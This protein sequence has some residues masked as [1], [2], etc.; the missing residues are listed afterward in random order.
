MAI[1]SGTTPIDH[2]SHFSPGTVF[3]LS[4]VGKKYAYTELY[5]FPTEVG[6]FDPNAVTLGPDGNLY[7]T[8]FQGGSTY[9]NSLNGYGVVFEIAL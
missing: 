3:E 8:T 9:Q 6:G 2:Q 7:G 5:D 4:P 1:S